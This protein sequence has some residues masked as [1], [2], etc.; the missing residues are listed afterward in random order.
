M[1]D[2]DILRYISREVEMILAYLRTGTK[3]KADKLRILFARSRVF[4]VRALRLDAGE[5][6]GNRAPK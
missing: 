3:Q 4:I 5:L 1:R 6:G 2:L